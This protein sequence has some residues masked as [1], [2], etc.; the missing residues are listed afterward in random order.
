MQSH[1]D[2]RANALKSHDNAVLI[3]PF[4]IIEAWRW[5]LQ[6][7]Y[8]AAQFP[9]VMAKPIPHVGYTRLHLFDVVLA[10]RIVEQNVL[11]FYIFN[12]AAVLSR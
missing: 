4:A 9:Q 1:A 2:A 6:P 8:M 5:A 11:V 10:Y 7:T 12:K 3:C